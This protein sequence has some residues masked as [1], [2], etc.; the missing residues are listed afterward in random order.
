M[1]RAGRVNAP[2]RH[3][4]WR[5]DPRGIGAFCISPG[6]LNIASTRDIAYESRL[7]LL[8][9]G[10]KKP[11]A[12]L[13]LRQHRR[14]RRALRNRRARRG[15]GT[16]YGLRVKVLNA[17]FQSSEAPRPEIEK[18][19]LLTGELDMVTRPDETLEQLFQFLEPIKPRARVLVDMHHVVSIDAPS[20]LAL[21]ALVRALGDRHGARVAGNYPASERARKALIDAD[22]A[23][24]M[25]RYRSPPLTTDK[26]LKLLCGLG[27]EKVDPVIATKIQEFLADRHPSLGVQERDAIYD[28]VT[29][30]VENV[31]THAFGTDEPTS[32][33]GQKRWYVVGIYD[34]L[35][36]TSTVAIL[37]L[38]VGVGTTVK[39]ALGRIK[40]VVMPLLQRPADVLE[41]ATLGLL[42][43]SGQRKH[44]KGLRTLKEFATQEGGRAFHVLSSG[45]MITWTRGGP[46]KRGVRHFPGTAVWLQISNVAEQA[47]G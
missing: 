39:R 18:V 23:G 34:E 37:D 6:L 20:V 42:T 13:R 11:T 21:C 12:Y 35:R 9:A 46:D 26:S 24:F 38:G 28:A 22:F 43:E 32:R 40:R 7:L 33:V 17:R 3:S 5:P 15:V 19:Y 4:D 30:C 44:G 1:C 14:A 47:G 16:R 41:E 45:G 31:K 29:A 27:R 2:S 8:W 36:K 10:M 25:R